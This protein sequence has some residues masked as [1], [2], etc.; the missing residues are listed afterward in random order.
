MYPTFNPTQYQPGG[1]FGQLAQQP[2]QNMQNFQQKYE[3]IHVNGRSGAE[4]FQMP[5][6]SQVLLLDETAP[7]VWFKSTDGAGYPTLTAY[8][9]VPAQTAEQ[10]EANRYDALEQ[11]IS[12]LEVLIA[13]GSK[14]NSRGSKPKQTDIPD[15]AD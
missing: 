3:V 1:Y 6:N 14:S 8:D 10:K 7:I 4:A 13:S 15:S 9:I 2:F 5:P 12:T 11:R